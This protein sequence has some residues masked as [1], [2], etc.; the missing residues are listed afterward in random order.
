AKELDTKIQHLHLTTPIVEDEGLSNLEDIDSSSK[1][2][3][4]IN[5][6]IDMDKN[7]NNDDNLALNELDESNSEEQVQEWNIFI[8]EWFQAIEHENKCNDSN[9][10]IFLTDKIDNNFS[11]GEK[12]VHP[13]NDQTAKWLLA[14]LVVSDLELLTY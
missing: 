5:N 3:L 14:I 8:E 6:I 13:A 12:K 2:D 1:D 11:F 9:D 10:E 4:Q 7:I